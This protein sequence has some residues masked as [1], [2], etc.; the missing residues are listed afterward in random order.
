MATLFI[1]L[2]Q[3]N[4]PLEKKTGVRNLRDK[5]PHVAPFSNSSGAEF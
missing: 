2:M 3:D 5:A 4:T 1:V